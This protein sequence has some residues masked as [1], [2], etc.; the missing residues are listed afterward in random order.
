MLANQIILANTW[1][2]SFQPLL[3]NIYND[4]LKKKNRII[5]YILFYKQHTIKNCE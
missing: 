4:T 5:E 1:V 2:T 3:C